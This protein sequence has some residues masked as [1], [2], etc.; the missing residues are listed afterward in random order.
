MIMLT[1]RSWGNWLYN[2]VAYGATTDSPGTPLII[3]T[4]SQCAGFKRCFNVL[5]SNV[6]YT[7]LD[8]AGEVK[9]WMTLC[10][11]I[12]VEIRCGLP[13][14]D[15]ALKIKISRLSVPPVKI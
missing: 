15:W 10:S 2:E 4:A 11:L 5:A 3:N 6:G 12:V 1:P 8:G 7:R 14:I 9:N 13:F